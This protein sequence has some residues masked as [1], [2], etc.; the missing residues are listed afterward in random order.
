MGSGGCATRSR[1]F[2]RPAGRCKRLPNRH[3]QHDRRRPGPGGAEPGC[4]SI[5]E[6]EPDGLGRGGVTRVLIAVESAI[7]RKGLEAILAASP[8]L[9]VVASEIAGTSDWKQHLQE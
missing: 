4:L 8:N 1:K 5:S 6:A 9:E 2:G 3:Q 7:L